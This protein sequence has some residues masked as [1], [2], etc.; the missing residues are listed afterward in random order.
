MRET[1]DVF[2]RTRCRK[3][4]I[5]HSELARRAGLSR[6]TLYR[7]MRGEIAAP[8]IATLHGL[9]VGLDV[10][11]LYLLRHYFSSYH[12]EQEG[13]RSPS[14]VVGDRFAFI[15]DVSIA[16]NEILGT[17][18][19][20][21]KTWLIQ[22][23]GDVVW[24]SRRLLCVDDDYV[25]ARPDPDG[26]LVPVVVSRVQPDRDEVEVPDLAPGE[27]S[28]ITI[29]FTA[30]EQ[31]GTVVSVWKMVD[32]EGWFCYPGQQIDLWLKVRVVAL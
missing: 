24:R 19:H 7:L 17:R 26:F 4:K 3:L 8:S 14:R 15:R 32:A 10:S 9:S 22:N 25:I 20:F 27:S 13:E 28:E 29:R 2:I 21:I 12:H 5:S 18:Q 6:E 1:L 31:P 30:P 16:D 11:T 23:V